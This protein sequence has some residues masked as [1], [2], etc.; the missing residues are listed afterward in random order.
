[1]HLEKK[2]VVVLAKISRGKKLSLLNTS[3]FSSLRHHL[4]WTALIWTEIV[5]QSKVWIKPRNMAPS[6]SCRPKLPYRTEWYSSS[7]TAVIHHLYHC[8]CL[9][10][11]GSLKYRHWTTQGTVVTLE[12]LSLVQRLFEQLLYRYLSIRKLS[13]DLLEKISDFRCT[14]KFNYSG[15]SAD[16][17]DV[18]KT[19]VTCWVLIQTT[20]SLF[21]DCVNHLLMTFNVVLCHF[22][23]FFHSCFVQYYMT[24]MVKVRE[25]LWIWQINLFGQLKHMV[26]VFLSLALG[27]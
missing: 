26:K 9:D 24:T 6:W 3:C 8:D 5:P 1:M 22:V 15:Q 20:T 14:N 4:G 7:D 12:W 16:W 17:I 2:Q 23:S 11:W 25:E 19:S 27:G 13:D 21:E 18:T 10:E